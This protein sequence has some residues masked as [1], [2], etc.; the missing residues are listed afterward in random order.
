M[1]SVKHELATLLRNFGTASTI[2]MS[3]VFSIMAGVISGYYIDTWLFDGKT[4]P[5]F[6]IIFFVFGVAGGVKNFFILTK[7]FSKE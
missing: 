3:I 1:A 4:S 6:T 7:R 2:A 5:W